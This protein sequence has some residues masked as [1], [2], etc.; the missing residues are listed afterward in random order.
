MNEFTDEL[1]LE[2]GWA[3]VGSPDMNMADQLS[4]FDASSLL[5]V[6]KP[7]WIKFFHS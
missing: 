1:V 6:T 3:A 2:I 5:H 7:V 4:Q